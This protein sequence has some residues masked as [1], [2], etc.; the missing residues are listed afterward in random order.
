MELQD[1]L[2]HFQQNN[3]H[4]YAISYDPVETLKTFAEKHHIT[5]PLLS[6]YG[7]TAIRAFGIFNADVPPDKK[8]YGVPHPGTYIVNAQGIVIDKS[9]HEHY[10]VRD[11]I[12]SMLQQRLHIDPQGCP[13]QTIEN[14]DLKAVVTL[15]SGTIRRGQVQTLTLNITLKNNRHIYSPN[16]EGG[17]TP[18]RLTFDEIEDVQFGEV[19]YPEPKPLHLKALNETLPVFT[20]HITLKTNLTNLKR[21][22]FV[23]R[24][25]LHYQACDD[26]DCY[27]PQKMAFELPLT[28]LENI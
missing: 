27:L 16:I 6:D 25:H 20:N 9:F 1:K 10:A 21:E 7:S 26:R 8:S 13:V 11:S 14:E 5:Y 2:T 23:V 12:A 28:Y 3:I 18:T 17:Y 24:A 4:P 15:S 22:S 19:F